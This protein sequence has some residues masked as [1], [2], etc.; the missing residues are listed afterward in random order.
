MP[1]KG[2]LE[3][4]GETERAEGDLFL[5]VMGLLDEL[6]EGVPQDKK[7]EGLPQDQLTFLHRCVKMELQASPYE[8]RGSR[9]AA[10]LSGFIKVNLRFWRLFCLHFCLKMA[11]KK[12]SSYSPSFTSNAK[13]CCCFPKTLL[14][15]FGKDIL[16]INKRQPKACTLMLINVCS[17]T[18]GLR[19]RCLLL[20]SCRCSW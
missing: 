9:R 6:M 18:W 16:V 4:S 3:F 10:L 14:S 15:I 8:L 20:S 1:F 11:L 13:R 12:S 17:Q 7:N 19:Q 2:S 5:L